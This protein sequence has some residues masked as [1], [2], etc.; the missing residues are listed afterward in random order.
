MLRENHTQVKK[1]KKRLKKQA[2]KPNSTVFSVSEAFSQVETS[3]NRAYKKENLIH[4]SREKHI[5]SNSVAREYKTFLVEWPL[6]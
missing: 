6:Q 1:K 5:K 3:F 4:R 2:L